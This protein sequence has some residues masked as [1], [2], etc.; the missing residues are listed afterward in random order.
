[1]NKTYTT[2]TKLLLFSDIFY[3]INLTNVIS[4]SWPK[5]YIQIYPHNYFLIIPSVGCQV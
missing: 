2:G 4:V 1:M 5:F 3:G